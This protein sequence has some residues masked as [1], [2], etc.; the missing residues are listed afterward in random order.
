MSLDDDIIK[1]ILRVCRERCGNMS[2]DQGNYGAPVYEPEIQQRILSELWQNSTEFRL[3]MEVRISRSSKYHKSQDD[4]Y[5]TTIDSLL[6][7]WSNIL[8]VCSGDLTAVPEWFVEHYKNRIHATDTSSPTALKRYY[9]VINM[10][11]SSSS[12]NANID[13]I[14]NLEDILRV[15]KEKWK[16]ISPNQSEYGLYASSINNLEMQQKILTDMWNKSLYFQIC[17]TSMFNRQIKIYG[18]HDK[19][20]EATIGSIFTHWA[21]IF[22]LSSDDISLVPEWYADYC[23]TKVRD[24]D[25]KN[26]EIL[27][28][29][30]DIITAKKTHTMATSFVNTGHKLNN[31]LKVCQKRWHDIS[32][33]QGIYGTSIYETEIQQ[34]LLTDMW[35]NSPQFQLWMTNIINNKVEICRS[36]Y[37]ADESLGENELTASDEICI[38]DEAYEL[39]LTKLFSNWV[40]VFSICDDITVVPEWFV[41][42]CKNRIHDKDTSSP[43][44]IERYYDAI[45]KKQ[46]MSVPTLPTITA[47][48]PVKSTWFSSTIYP[49]DVRNNTNT[50]T[51]SNKVS[52][53]TEPVIQ[54]LY[55]LPLSEPVITEAQISKSEEEIEE[56]YKQ[57]YLETV[58]EAENINLDIAWQDA[59][60]NPVINKPTKTT[61]PVK[62]VKTAEH[63]R[64]TSAMDVASI[65]QSNQMMISQV[66]R[67]INSLGFS[68]K[69]NC[70]I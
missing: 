36:M 35:N 30:Y 15:C 57:N 21:N 2:P 16:L 31:I 20:Y 6:H 7:H 50:T 4:V 61:K 56:F 34:K 28:T 45:N 64:I 53:I 65:S 23:K 70:S 1:N 33:D 8:S 17:V 44:I 52:T 27:K 47:N 48:E 51:D 14:C 49:T 42:H 3:F 59:L 12:S 13:I 11:A 60:I 32:N 69:I 37:K 54:E 39:A 22:V 24:N 55:E 10:A 43:K 18:S 66:N 68:G 9:D 25:V 5:E 26:N 67:R 40:S 19:A 41:D 29:Y 63:L 38:A 62:P 46:A 58:K